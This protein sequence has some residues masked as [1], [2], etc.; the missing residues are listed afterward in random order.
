[1]ACALKK[2]IVGSAG[3]FG[4]SPRQTG[5][6]EVQENEISNDGTASVKVLGG[7][8]VSIPVR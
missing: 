1:M 3:R 7:Q 8:L 2:L 4:G 6:V 5:W